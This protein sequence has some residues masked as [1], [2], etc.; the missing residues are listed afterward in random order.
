MKP[1]YFILN[2]VDIF[3]IDIILHFVRKWWNQLSFFHQGLLL[4]RLY[5]ISSVIRL[6][7]A[8]E[9]KEGSILMP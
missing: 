1:H 4:M 3:S 6:V 7:V 5:V 9:P 2:F 8:S